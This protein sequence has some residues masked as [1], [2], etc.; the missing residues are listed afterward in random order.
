MMMHKMV[1]NMM[2]MA[3]SM[4]FVMA[5]EEE[6]DMDKVEKVEVNFLASKEFK[7]SLFSNIL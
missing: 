5:V 3:L 6:V 2:I 7:V 4:L 1:L